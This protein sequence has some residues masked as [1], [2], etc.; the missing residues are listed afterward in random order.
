MCYR[1]VFVFGVAALY[2][3]LGM[4]SPQGMVQE[5]ASPEECQAF[6]EKIVADYERIRKRHNK[7]SNIEKTAD[8]KTVVD[9]G[10]FVEVMYCDGA[11]LHIVAEPKE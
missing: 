5:H 9:Q 1:Q 7:E 11:T 8:G 10:E 4:S 2:A 6:I 3:S